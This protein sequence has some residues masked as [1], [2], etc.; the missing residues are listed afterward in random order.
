M[1]YAL[2]NY[3]RILSESS[4]SILRK[5]AVSFLFLY[6]ALQVIITW[7]LVSAFY[8]TIYATVDM[9]TDSSTV[10]Y[11]LTS[12][13]AAV[14]VGQVLLAVGD[15]PN[16]HEVLYSFVYVVQGIFF[17]WCFGYIL[18]YTISSLSD[19]TVLAIGF[20]LSLVIYLIVTFIYGELMSLFS[21]FIQY[22]FLVPTFM[23][24]FPIYSFSNVHDISW[25]TKDC[26]VLLFLFS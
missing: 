25:G 3:P 11:I 9:A 2:K 13:Y 23:V 22:L 26:K 5:T 24:T 10:I 18:Y 21:S 6:Y 1:L 15:K 14:I 20:F 4:H 8:L 19:S 12:I 17:L 16:N 7:F